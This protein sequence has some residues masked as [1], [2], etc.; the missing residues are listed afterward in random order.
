MQT[1]SMVVTVRKDGMKD[2]IEQHKLFMTSLTDLNK[3]VWQLVMTPHLFHYE[4]ILEYDVT[5][6]SKK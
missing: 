5:G 4:Q 1:V 2:R 6:F 3:N